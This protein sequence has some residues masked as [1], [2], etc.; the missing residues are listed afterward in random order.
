ML[1]RYCFIKSIFVTS[2][3]GSLWESVKGICGQIL[4]AFFT[5]SAR[6]GLLSRLNDRSEGL[7]FYTEAD[8]VTHPK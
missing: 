6:N 2:P 7:D 1:D 5:F 4:P 8:L 3:L